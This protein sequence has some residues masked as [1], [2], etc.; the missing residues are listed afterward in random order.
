MTGLLV[1]HA[2]PAAHLAAT[3]AA[4]DA[5]EP[6]FAGHPRWPEPLLAEA[7]RQVPVGTR[8][9]GAALTP[10][11]LAPC[12]W[13]HAWRGRVLIPTGG[14]GGRVKFAIHTR[15]TLRAAATALRD[16][17]VA[18]GLKPTLHG[19]ILTPPWHVS[20]LMPAIRARETGGAFAVLDGRLDPATPLPAVE[21]PTG[22]TRVASLV[23]AQLARLLARADGAAWLRQFDVILLGGGTTPPALL[24][25]IKAQRL[26]VALTYGM[27]E[28]AA[29]AALAWVADLR[30]GETPS[31]T[32]LPGTTLT[33]PEGRIH[34]ASPSLCAGYWP[35]TPIASPHDTGDLGAVQAGRVSVSGRADRIVITGG[36]KV[37]PARVESAL[38]A[39]GLAKAAL[40]LGLPDATWGQLL[41]AVVIAP[42]ALEPALRAAAERSLEPAA[43]PRRYLFVAELPFDTR[44]KI[45]AERLGGL[46]A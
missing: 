43:R 5:G 15:G 42:A 33:A 12:D 39:P 44:G 16:A 25:E 24:T 22:G 38:T 4:L 41:V 8:V 35:A 18:R 21:L 34:V 3:L 1:M 32:P 19:A 46:L 14:T 7:L 29:A 37:D 6:V 26:P 13:P 27:T 2:D 17:L 28:T 40:V 36:E 31:G 20:G 10:R 11:G 45:D 9:V 23:P 30:E